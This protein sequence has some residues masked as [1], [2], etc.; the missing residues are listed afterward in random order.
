MLRVTPQRRLLFKESMTDYHII[1]E[2]LCESVSQKI[3]QSISLRHIG[4]VD[5]FKI[6]QVSNPQI[7]LMPDVLGRFLDYT[8]GL[9]RIIFLVR[10]GDCHHI[11]EL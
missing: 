5:E 4:H 8:S 7:P 10:V 6:G 3:Y 2:N 11:V 9:S 1:C